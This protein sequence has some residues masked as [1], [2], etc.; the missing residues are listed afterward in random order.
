VGQDEPSA[1]Q[2][3]STG[4]GSAINSP[5][6]LTEPQ[7]GKFSENLD[8]VRLPSSVSGKKDP[9]NVLKDCVSRSYHPKTFPRLGP[10][11][12]VVVESLRDPTGSGLGVWLAG[13]TGADDVNVSP[14]GFRVEAVDVVPYRSGIEGRRFILE[15]LLEDELGVTVMLDIADRPDVE[16]GESEGETVSPIS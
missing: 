9:W 1:A 6:D 16:S 8:A 14:P 4:I 12:S 7:R 13:E 11:V 15:P 2:V 10:E 3:G 5:L